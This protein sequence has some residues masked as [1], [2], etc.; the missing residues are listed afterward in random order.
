MLA[1][2]AVL[3]A[4]KERVRARVGGRERLGRAAEVGMMMVEDKER[5]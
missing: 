2:L 5:R 3:A 1:V 4:V